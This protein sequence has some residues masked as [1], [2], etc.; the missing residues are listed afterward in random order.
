MILRLAVLIQ[1]RR[2]TD[3]QMDRQT[4]DEAYTTL[5]KHRVVKMGHVTVITLLLT[6]VCHSCAVTRH[7]IPVYKI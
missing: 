5:A 1:Y 2:V 4:H 6:V 3:K 7:S